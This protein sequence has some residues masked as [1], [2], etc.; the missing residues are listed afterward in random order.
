M[1]ILLRVV[2]VVASIFSLLIGALGQP[3]A[4]WPQDAQ[5]LF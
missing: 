1:M 2:A 5:R 3:Q 4:G